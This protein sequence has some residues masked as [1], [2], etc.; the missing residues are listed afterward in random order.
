[1]AI[2]DE[3]TTG[4]KVWGN[5]IGTDKDGTARLAD[6]WSNSTGVIIHS[7]ATG[8]LIGGI[9]AGEDATRNIISGNLQD[10]VVIEDVGTQFNEVLGNYIGTNK[11]GTAQVYNGASNNS[12]IVIRNG[13]TDNIIGT[14]PLD[15]LDLA[16]RKRNVISGNLTF[17]V[18]IKD[19]GTQRNR[20]NGNYIGPSKNGVNYI[21]QTLNRNKVGLLITDGTSNKFIGAGTE[22]TRN[23]ISGNDGVGVEIRGGENHVEQNYIGTDAGGTHGS[24]ISS[25][26]TSAKPVTVK[27]KTTSSPATSRSAFG[28][29]VESRLRPVTKSAITLSAPTRMETRVR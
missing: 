19:E 5:Y 26:S 7:G 6:G 8:N 15:S 25:A 18:V 4:N 23:V 2:E 27:S 1:M 20:V 11:D 16:V 24:V 29:A 3:E 17:G 22:Q 21:P 10:G 12:G 28:L 14:A 13:A 9:E